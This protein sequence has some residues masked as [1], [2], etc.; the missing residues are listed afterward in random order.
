MGTLTRPLE[1]F[2]VFV[3]GA[4]AARRVDLRAGGGGKFPG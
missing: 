2:A 4:W 1:G 3:E